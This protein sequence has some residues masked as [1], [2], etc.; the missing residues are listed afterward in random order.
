MDP[1][2]IIPDTWTVNETILRHPLTMEVFGRY[3]IDACC[4]GAFPIR[5]AAERHRIDPDALLAELNRVATGNEA[6][7]PATS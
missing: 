1:D 3:H 6:L 2:P 7:E 4:G 5:E